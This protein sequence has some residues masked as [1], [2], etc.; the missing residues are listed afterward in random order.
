[1]NAFAPPGAVDSERMRVRRTGEA[2]RPAPG[3]RPGRDT[4]DSIV[5]DGLRC[6]AARTMRANGAGTLGRQAAAPV[7][8][9][10]DDRV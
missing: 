1:M 2:V 6:P 8:G 7:L 4:K 9:R 3:Q 10:R 5:T